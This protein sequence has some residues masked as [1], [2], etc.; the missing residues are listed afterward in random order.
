M[1]SD[2]IAC[3]GTSLG[4][5]RSPAFDGPAVSVGTTFLVP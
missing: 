4:A 3:L 2:A 1:S 5:A